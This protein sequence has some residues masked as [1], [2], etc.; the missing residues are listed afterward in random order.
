M[1][2]FNIDWNGFDT[3]AGN[4]FRSLLGDSLFADVTLACDDG[5]QITAHKLVLVTS[6]KF[7]RNII[8]QNPHNH[9]LIYMRGVKHSVLQSVM[10]FIYL[11]KAEVD[12]GHLQTFMDLA[13]DLEIMGLTEFKDESQE[14]IEKH[15]KQEENDFPYEN[16]EKIVDQETYLRAE[17]E[18]TMTND[19]ASFEVIEDE[20]QDDSIANQDNM[21][22]DLNVITTKTEDHKFQCDAM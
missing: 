13:K 8:L 7:F 9:P 5:K 15:T 14:L 19:T 20:S 16:D 12:Q 1:E 10:D 18:T 22:K 3:S 4:S 2:K 6:S 11:G 17:E 21:L